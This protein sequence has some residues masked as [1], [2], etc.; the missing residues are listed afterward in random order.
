VLTMFES[1][2]TTT[3]NRGGALQEDMLPKHLRAGS[4]R[5]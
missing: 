2:R 1:L 5:S 3:H 4:A